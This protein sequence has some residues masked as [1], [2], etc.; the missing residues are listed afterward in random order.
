[1]LSEN[2]IFFIDVD[3]IY[4]VLLQMCGTNFSYE[5]VVTNILKDYFFC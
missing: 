2:L 4:S 1:V 3:V 5:R